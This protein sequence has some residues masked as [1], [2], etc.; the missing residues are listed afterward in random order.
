MYANSSL[1]RKE[2]NTTPRTIQNSCPRPMKLKGL[3]NNPIKLLEIQIS[4]KSVVIFRTIVI[5][6]I[7]SCYSRQL[8][9]I[10]FKML[11]RNWTKSY[12]TEQWFP[13]VRG[14]IFGTLSE[15]PSM[16]FSMR[17]DRILMIYKERR[18]MRW[19]RYWKRPILSM[20]S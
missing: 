11:I 4:A 5:T 16:T 8:L 20:C 15:P 7:R 18:W 9:K 12:K 2:W 17:C 14:S 6:T 19:I 10:S 3:S 13:I 1:L